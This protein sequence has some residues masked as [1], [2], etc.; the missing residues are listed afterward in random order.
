VQRTGVTPPTNGVATP[1]IGAVIGN[2]AGGAATERELRQQAAA[3]RE[4]IAIGRFELEQALPARGGGRVYVYRVTLADG[5]QTTYGNRDALLS[6]PILGPAHEKVFRK[7][8]AEERGRYTGEATS[9]A[10]SAI[11]QYEVFLPDGTTETYGTDREPDA[12]VRARRRAEL[13]RAIAQQRGTPFKA[14]AGPDGTII[15]LLKVTLADGTIKT[16]ASGQPK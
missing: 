14:I 9:D 6:E 11:Y 15:S 3:I 10:G 12:D 8:I 13:D 2:V 7:A 4:A 5:R 1:G 16:Y